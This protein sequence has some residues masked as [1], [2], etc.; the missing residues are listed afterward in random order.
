MKALVYKTQR[1]DL[2]QDY[3]GIKVELASTVD[4]LQQ[5]NKERHYFE[6]QYNLQL[7]VVT[8][9]E[10]K[11]QEQEQTI[12]E[13]NAQC[14][15]QI[16]VLKELH[17]AMQEEKKKSQENTDQLNKYNQDLKLTLSN[18]TKSLTQMTDDRERWKTRC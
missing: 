3:T 12:H 8:K 15:K 7:G 13:L 14:M 10:R 11:C 1:D 16:E 2:Q 17:L 6:D 5:I 4:H 18:T 9:L